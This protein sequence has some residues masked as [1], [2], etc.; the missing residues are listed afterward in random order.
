M[1]E[2]MNITPLGMKI[3]TFL[4][5]H[6][7]KEFYV[8]E[9][10]KS[11]KKS[12]GGTHTALK[13]LHNL[14]LIIEKTSGKNLYYR[15]NDTNPSVKNFKIFMTTTELNSLIYELK[16]VADK[17]MLFGSC[18]TGEDTSDSDI[19]LFIL[20]HD[21]IKVNNY[22]KK[23]HLERTIQAVVVDAA[24]LVKIKEKDKAFYQEINKGLI[25]WE[26]KN[27]E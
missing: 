19:D 25:L 18:A 23:K 20:T 9:I 3:L 14:N 21:T 26:D 5:R 11:I 1:S 6:P 22:L 17:I 2:K 4:A 16:K 13:S 12:L 7:D 27:H 15:V 24:G 8:R 10:A